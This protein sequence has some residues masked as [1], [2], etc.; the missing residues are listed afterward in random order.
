MLENKDKGK[1]KTHKGRVLEL[2]EEV[3]EAEIE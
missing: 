3:R 1:G 2:I